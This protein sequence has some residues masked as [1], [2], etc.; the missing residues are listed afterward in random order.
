MGA[1]YEWLSRCTVVLAAFWKSLFLGH[2][3]MLIIM[4]W[5]EGEQDHIYNTILQSTPA[6]QQHLAQTVNYAQVFIGGAIIQ[7]A[8][9]F[10]P[11]SS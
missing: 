1:G 4:I 9:S 10:G 7:T 6:A 2:P 3:V 11:Q 8:S 5:S